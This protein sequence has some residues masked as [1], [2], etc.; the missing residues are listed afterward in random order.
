MKRNLLICCLLF[1]FLQVVAQEPDAKKLLAKL[2]QTQEENKKAELLSQLCEQVRATHPQEAISYGKR[3]IAL[4]TRTDNKQVLAQTYNRIGSIYNSLGDYETALQYYYESLKLGKV[5]DDNLAIA[6][7]YGNIGSV[8]FRQKQYDQAL[9]FNQKALSLVQHK[10]DTAFLG[11]LYNNIGNIYLEKNLYDKALPYYQKAL[12]MKE[13][14]HDPDG[15]RS[16]L[17]NIGSIHSK[18]GAYKRALRYHFRA[19]VLGKGIRR[20]NSLIN[21]AEDYRVGKQY[22]KALKYANLYLQEARQYQAKEDI[23][24]AADFLSKVYTSLGDYRRAHEYLTLSVAYKDS[25]QNE[26]I[27]QQLASFQVRYETERKENEN[28][29][30]KAQSALQAKQLQQQKTVAYTVG[31]LLLMAILLIVVAYKGKKRLQL[32]N[33]QLS[34]I[35]Q[36][37]VHY[38]QVLNQQKE[39]LQQLNQIKNKFFSIIAHDLRSP[40]ASLRSL[41]QLLSAGAL[42]E[43]QLRLFAKT[44]ETEQQNTLWLLDNLLNW[45]STQMNGMHVKPEHINLKMLAEE[46][47]LLL[48]PQAQHKHIQLQNHIVAQQTAF[49]DPEMIRLVLR[50][51]LANAIK[52]CQAGDRISLEAVA[53]Q[54]QITITVRDTGVGISPEN[55]AKIFA[56]GGMSTYGTAMEK[57]SGLGLTLCKDFIERNGGRIWV[58]SE[59]GI[60]SAFRF[61]LPLALSESTTVNGANQK[62]ASV[63]C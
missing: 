58:E 9:Q 45:A 20:L 50:N 37:I 36:Q 24:Y 33:R 29:R 35:N 59:P 51:L 48:E 17:N 1:A 63:V 53:L 56:L 31:V 15:V 8:Y 54:Q 27:T 21:I 34:E 28:L 46:N 11:K 49:A 39:E 38:N 16:T 26:Q 30:L 61:S 25:L 52:F 3:A 5:M 7:S 13:V 10:Q 12:E 40:L 60:G 41:I 19:L 23:Q 18:K 55:Q 22:D 6:K 47:L 32:A 57:G 42:Q 44:L 43:A 14:I 2:E 4:A 62:R